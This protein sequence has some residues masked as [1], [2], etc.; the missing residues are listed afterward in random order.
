MG[1]LV[2]GSVALDSVQTPFGRA[3]RVLGGS[4]TFFSVS[5]SYFTEVDLVAVV[6]DDFAEDHIR[7][8]ESRN[9][10]LQGLQR[11]PGKTFFWEGK[12]HDDLNQRDTLDT[13]LNVFESFRPEIPQAY[14][15]DAH[16]FLGNI[17]PELQLEVLD[18]VEEPRLVA[19]DT[20]NYWI[21]GK[22]EALR[23]VLERVDI[24]L[25]NDSEVHELSGET[26]LVK[27][28]RAVLAMGPSTLVVKRGEYGA[29]MFSEQG[30]FWAPAY[31]LEEVFDPTGAGDAFAGGFMG[32]L[33]SAS[34]LGSGEL[35]RAI[36]FGSA[37][38]SFVVEAFSLDRLRDLDFTAIQRRFDDFRRLTY[39]EALS[40]RKG[41]W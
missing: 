37:I 13:Q 30:S 26:N 22:P 36:I 28:A 29:L 23:R 17:D 35:K 38:A 2:V 19:C 31:P 6:G 5:A 40:A 8:L 10:D 11:V 15:N 27:G 18:Q 39:F 12:Y 9:V 20:M 3:E 33:G 34:S 32:Y 1:V 25:I 14:R 16:I 7:F 4:A 41:R 24:L 21:E